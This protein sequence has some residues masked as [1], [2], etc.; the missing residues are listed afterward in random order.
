MLKGFG[1][2]TFMVVPRNL[3]LVCHF[4]NNS[5]RSEE[6]FRIFTQVGIQTCKNLIIPCNSCPCILKYKV[7]MYF[8]LQDTYCWMA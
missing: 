5:N 3:G 8:L 1:N 2:E 4:A 7:A 6:S